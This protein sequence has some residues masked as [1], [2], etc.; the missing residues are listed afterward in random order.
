VRVQLK[1]QEVRQYTRGYWL[2]ERHCILKNI[3][4]IT[5]AYYGKLGESLMRASRERINWICS[6]ARGETIL[7]VG[8]SQGIATILLAREGKYVRGLDICK[9][10]IDYATAA[11]AEED[12]STQEHA[13]FIQADFISHTLTNH[14]CYDAIIMSEVLEHVTDP[15]RFIQRAYDRLDD[16][17]ILVTT[18]PFGIND[19]HDHKRTY[20]TAEL[21][22]SLREY[23]TV[24]EVTFFGNWIGMVG[25]KAQGVNGI[26]LNEDL[27]TRTEKAFLVHERELCD[28]I[29]RLQNTVSVAEE[30]VKEWKKRVEE[31]TDELT[32]MRDLYELTIG[33]NKDIKM[34]AEEA[35]SRNDMLQ[36]KLDDSQTLVHDLE[37]QNNTL[38]L[39]ANK[40]HRECKTVRKKH[41]ILLGQYEKLAG[42]KLGKRQIS[43][44]KRQSDKRKKGGGAS[45]LWVRIK[46]RL[47]KY[48]LLLFVVRKLR[49]KNV[50]LK[51]LQQKSAQTK[52]KQPQEAPLCCDTGY[53]S[54]IEPLLR[55]MPTSSSGRF[56]RKSELKV[57]MITDDFLFN[58]YKDVANCVAL[59]PDHWHDQIR[60]SDLLFIISG[61]KGIGEEWRGISL[62]KT[63]SRQLVLKIIEYCKHNNIPAVFYSIEDPPNYHKFIEIARHC[64]Y[65]FTAASEM[66]PV[67]QSDCGHD[68]TY[69]LMNSA[70]PFFHNPVG[71]YNVPKLQEVLF[72]G[73]WYKC[74]PERGDDM[75]TI[76]DGVISSNRGLKIIDR[77]F[78]SKGGEFIFPDKYIPHISPEIPHELLQKVHKLYDWAININTV[79]ESPTMF[80]SRV[81][82]L[83]AIG[84]LLLSN[85]SVGVNSYLP[86]VYTVQDSGEVRRILDTL[87]PEE[88]RE[89]QAVGIRHAMAGNTCFDR[90][91][92]LSRHIGLPEIS[93][94]RTVAVVVKE[95]TERVICQFESQSYSD[96]ELIMEDELQSSYGR[97]DVV[98]FFDDRA[99]YG[100]FY[101]EDMINGFK[102]TDSDYITKDSHYRGSE[103]F[104]G[105]QHD[106]VDELSSKYRTVF[107][108]DAFSAHA[109]LD[110]QDGRVAL[111]RGY[112]IDCLQYNAEPSTMPLTKH[113]VYKL[114]VIIPIYNN[115]LC[116]YGKA[117]SSLLRSSMFGDME[118]I[119]VDDGSTDDTTGCYIKYLERHYDNVRTFFFGDGGSGSASRPRNKGVEMASA[120]HITFLDPDNEAIADGY[121]RLYEIALEGKYDLVVGNIVCFRE[122]GFLMDYYYRFSKVYGSDAVNGDKKEFLS[123]IS[124]SP[125]SIQAMM[126]ERRLITE[127]GIEEVVG[128]I[129][130]DSFFSWQLITSSERLKAV[131]FPVHIYYEAVSGSAVNAVGVGFF[132]KSHL[133]E[134]AQFKWLQDEGLLSDYMEKRFNNFFRDWF[135]KKL[136]ICNES[137]KDESKRIVLDIFNIYRDHYNWQDEVINGFIRKFT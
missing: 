135:L 54:R 106:F 49:G 14:T 69:V 45:L 123:K 105:R 113:T 8:C 73:S 128:A 129:G 43:I 30:S 9:E 17:G 31:R 66:L 38:E 134:E 119:L 4:L 125:M 44:W 27:F 32:C 36:A 29:S 89:R 57:A 103:L 6:Q 11:L 50:N 63:E 71:S 65:V 127:S 126:I 112:S 97:F 58:T 98:A 18:V 86:A 115:G 48:P 40:L 116:L 52:T 35:Q 61:W 74:Y 94:I 79:K 76:F 80:A 102:Y 100:E 41:K 62:E 3:D 10:S 26:C 46:R 34:R 23:F 16:S 68:R 121:A 37:M 60:S 87:S 77:N 130:Q 82:E 42:S 28:R 1:R 83:E 64:D 114:S 59:H 108:S 101:L 55:N 13:E 85:Y 51:D 72:S 96:K 132:S 118:I 111:P 131:N 91:A 120:D 2:Q 124:F 53:F 95:I 67:Y 137:E 133:L 107:W 33:D 104:G 22:N 5:E 24:S 20:Y 136:S 109:L 122:R 90:F 25:T 21:L 19:Y 7:D 39:K 56:Y 75:R 81:Y 88:I 93:Q 110:M 12:D 117:F 92:E 15:R 99:E 70:N 78:S 84:N 47:R